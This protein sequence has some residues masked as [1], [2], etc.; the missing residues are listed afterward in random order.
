LT[1]CELLE[2]EGD[3][4]DEVVNDKKLDEEVVDEEEE[5]VKEIETVADEDK[6]EEDVV[7]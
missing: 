6:D 5:I 4:D 3:S 1:T 2:L 7:E